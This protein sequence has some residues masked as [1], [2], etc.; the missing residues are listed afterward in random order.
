MSDEKCPKCGKLLVWYMIPAAS[1][2]TSL[3][4][5]CID[6]PVCDYAVTAHYIRNQLT[7]ANKALATAQAEVDERRTQVDK[8]L[9]ILDEINVAGGWF[10]EASSHEELPL[11]VKKLQAER[12]NL[13]AALTTP[14]GHKGVVDKAMELERDKLL[15][16]VELS[17]KRFP[18]STQ[19]LENEIAHDAAART[20]KAGGGEQGT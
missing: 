10:K 8:L 18:H 6:W 2:P 1:L 12:D 17:R 3:G 14:E 9:Q 15:E 20:A 16:V 4:W 13:Q 11:V 5:Q 19:S 7:Q